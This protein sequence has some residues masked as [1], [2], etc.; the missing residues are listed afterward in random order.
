MELYESRVYDKFNNLLEVSPLITTMVGVPALFHP[1]C[2]K[3]V[4]QHFTIPSCE[5][6]VCQHFLLAYSSRKVLVPALEVLDPCTSTLHWEARKLWFLWNGLPTRKCCSS[7]LFQVPFQKKL[8]IG[9]SRRNR[10]SIL[11]TIMS[12]HF[13]VCSTLSWKNRGVSWVVPIWRFVCLFVV[14]A[15]VVGCFANRVLFV[16]GDN[17]S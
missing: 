13:C 4:C 1:S 16:C 10:L 14:V 11:I 9:P 3:T 2:E 6:M 17:K 7:T 5:K 15:V 8:P 12:R